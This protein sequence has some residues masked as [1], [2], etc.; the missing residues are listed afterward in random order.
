MVIQ[1][2]S[3][4]GQGLLIAADA[5]AGPLPPPQTPELWAHSELTATSLLSVVSAA[6]VQPGSGL[7]TPAPR[8]SRWPSPSSS[9]P[10]EQAPVVPPPVPPPGWFEGGLP[11]GADGPPGVSPPVGSGAPG[12]AGA[13]GVP[14]SDGS[15]RPSRCTA[16]T[17]AAAGEEPQTR[18]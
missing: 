15:V 12:P 1:T 3:I 10:F 14:G 5:L 13:A 11:P 2:C 9:L 6:L 18:A 8:K 4:C 16:A 7:T 17:S